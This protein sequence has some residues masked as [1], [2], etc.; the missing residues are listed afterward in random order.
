[1]VGEAVGKVKGAI[2]LATGGLVAAQAG[3]TLLG[4]GRQLVGERGPE[5]ANFPAGTRITPLPPPALLPSQ[6]AGAGG[7][8]VVVPVYLDRRQIALA[9]GSYSA[10]TAAA[11]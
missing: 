8:Q 7:G 4:G 10:D 5:L 6:L 9:M 1:M 2:G 3:T 11:R